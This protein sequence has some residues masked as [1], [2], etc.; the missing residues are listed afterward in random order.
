MSHVI[1]ERGRG[2]SL[3][4]TGSDEPVAEAIPRA[5]KWQVF[6]SGLAEHLESASVQTETDALAVLKMIGHAYE[7]GGGGE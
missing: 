1:R 3:Y 7:A 6:A 5:C 4:L 2:H